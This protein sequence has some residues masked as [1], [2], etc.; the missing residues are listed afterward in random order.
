MPGATT[1]RHEDKITGGIPDISVS[2]NRRTVWLETKDQE[3]KTTGLQY[4]NLKRL[5]GFYIIF[6][7]CGII[8]VVDLNDRSVRKMNLA[9]VVDLVMEVLTAQ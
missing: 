6:I 5:K 4:E 2:L 1:F 9:G 7:D 3:L 8:I